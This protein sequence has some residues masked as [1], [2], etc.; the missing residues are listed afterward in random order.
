MTLADAA[1]QTDRRLHPAPWWWTGGL[2]AAMVIILVAGR[3]FTER[4]SVLPRAVNAIDL[5]M[6]P[7]LLPAALLWVLTKR[8]G[9][10]QGRP[11]ILLGLLFVLLWAVAWL[12]NAS[13]V[14]WMGA[15]LF[16]YGLIAPVVFMLL[17][18]NLGLGPR[19]ARGLERLLLALLVVNLVIG[20]YD[21]L[22]GIGT[23][24]AD[25]VFGTFGVNQN[26]FAFFLAS[27]MAYFVARWRYLRVGLTDVL[28]LLWSGIIFVL[29]G[30]QTLWVVF[31]V[32][33]GLALIAFGRISR[34][35]L[36]IGLVGAFAGVVAVSTLDF[37]RF[38]VTGV[39]VAGYNN[40][41]Q[42]GK[43]QLVRSLPQIYQ[44]RPWAFWL[45]VGP[46]SF[47]SRAF[48]SIAVMPNVPLGRTNVTAALVPPF[49]RSDLADQFIIPYLEARRY[50]L[51]GINTDGPFTSYVSVPVETGIF[52]AAAL[53]AIYGYVLLSLVRACAGAE[54][55]A[56]R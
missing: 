30:F 9:R 25:F 28:L 36:V 38:N 51:S 54:T 6:A 52:G 43:V 15:L 49:F 5:L 29:C 18:I 20:T 55:A 44:H 2:V 46:G 21:G 10:V 39:I 19:F 42:L 17:L 8:K 27:L 45:G 14:H 22:R 33:A 26:Q 56:T 23:G 34:R 32:A 41:D 11:L 1:P 48:R 7:A 53:F 4:I 40:F 16:V 3:F 12:M 50:L 31:P 13:D 35:L 24:S 47:N 37:T